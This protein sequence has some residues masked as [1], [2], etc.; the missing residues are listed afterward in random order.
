MN[1]MIPADLE[2]FLAVRAWAAGLGPGEPVRDVKT[3]VES[4]G[5]ASANTNTNTNTSI[6]TN[7]NTSI[8]TN[9]NTSIRALRRRVARCEGCI[10][11]GDVDGLIPGLYSP[12]LHFLASISIGTLSLGGLG[13][14]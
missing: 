5:V 14:S 2:H 7:T 1:K 4:E 12:V 13:S 8:S 11:S 10:L 6:S 9:T 3:G